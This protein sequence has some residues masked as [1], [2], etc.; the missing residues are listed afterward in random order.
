MTLHK[1]LVIIDGQINQLPNGDTIEGATSGASGSQQFFIQQ[2]Q[3]VLEAGKPFVW[4]KLDSNG[5]HIETYL[6]DGFL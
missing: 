6:F 4:Y 1:P 3:P 5:I 2:S